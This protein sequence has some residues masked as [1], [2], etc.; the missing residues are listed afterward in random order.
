MVRL[1]EGTKWDI[2]PRCDRCSELEE[3]CR[4]PPEPPPAPE[5][6]PPEKQTARL[7]V[8]KRKGGRTVTVIRGLPGEGNDLSALLKQ[9]KDECGAG[10]SVK[11]EHLEIQGKQLDRVRSCLQKIGYKV[12][13]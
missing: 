6:I 5:L 10:G 1:F 12:K 8:E 7:A 11:E 3:D 13:G 9:L 2:P 4:C